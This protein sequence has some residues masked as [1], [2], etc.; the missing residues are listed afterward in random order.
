MLY[1]SMSLSLVPHHLSAL[2]FC[3][4]LL[5]VKATSKQSV[6]ADMVAK[7]CESGRYMFHGKRE[8]TNL[9][10]HKTQMRYY[11]T[12]CFLTLKQW[13]PILCYSYPV[14]SYIRYIG[15]QIHLI[16]YSNSIHKTQF[17]IR[18]NS[19]CVGTRL[20]SS[21][22]LWMQRIISPTLHLTY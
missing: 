2:L 10:K 16:K 12:G 19:T 13:I 17:M 18:I 14:F 3:G 7:Q 1:G 6:F 8:A 21:G 20:Q 5:L 4:N 9:A 15:Q 11:C 22:S